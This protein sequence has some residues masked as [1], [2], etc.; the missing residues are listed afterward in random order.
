[1]GGRLDEL[2]SSNKNSALYLLKMREFIQNI[3]QIRKKENVEF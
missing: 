1:V 3:N 2:E